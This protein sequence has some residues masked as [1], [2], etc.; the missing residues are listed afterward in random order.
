MD[1]LL[2]AL[3][4]QGVPGAAA[5][6]IVVLGL[7]F[8]AT[9]V[10]R[11]ARLVTARLQARTS[12]ISLDSPL[13]VLARRETAVSLVTTTVEIIAFVV[14][15]TLS[16]VVL[17]GAR[18][19]SA[20]AGASFAAVVVGFAAQRFLM[21]VIAGIVMFAEGWY[22]V[23]STVVIEPWKLEGVVEEISVRATKIRDVSGAILRVHNSQVLAVRLL[24]D[25]AHTYELELFVRDAHAG[26]V[27]IESAAALV[28]T[29]AT[30]FVRTPQLRATQTLDDDLFR[31]TADLAVAPGRGW[32]A[33]GLLPSLLKE[34]APDDLIVH[35]PVLLPA[36]EQSSTRFARAERLLHARRRR[37]P[38]LPI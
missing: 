28:P 17:T 2:R 18:G 21:D 6:T 29:G 34:R 4:H 15:I 22:T 5:K 14:A 38:L 32:L 36:D 27:L 31:L 13:M 35:G 3:E 12:D 7:F 24:P 20:L 11:L 19:V 25:G 9:L 16:L 33:E 30:A 37:R 8:V 1:G 23:G 10:A 26:A